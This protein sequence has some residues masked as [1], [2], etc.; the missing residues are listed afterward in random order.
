MTHH[1]RPHHH[2]PLRRLTI[3]LIAVS[4][5]TTLAAVLALVATP[6]LTSMVTPLPTAFRIGAGQPGGSEVSL[7]SLFELS[8]PPRYSAVSGSGYVNGVTTTLPQDDIERGVQSTL[9][10]TLFA[11]VNGELTVYTAGFSPVR[12]SASRTSSGEYAFK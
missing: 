12:A 9:Q 8:M 7:P 1:H 4:A 11:S 2:R 3:E 6:T 5:V 10:H